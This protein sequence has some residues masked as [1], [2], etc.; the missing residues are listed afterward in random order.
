MTLLFA[1]C[2]SSSSSFFAPT[3]V[4]LSSFLSASELWFANPKIQTEFKSRCEEVNSI[5]SQWRVNADQE[6]DYSNLSSAVDRLA[7]YIDFA[8]RADASSSSSA[9]NGFL[10]AVPT[11]LLRSTSKSLVIVERKTCHDVQLFLKLCG[12][13]RRKLDLVGSRVSSSVSH[14][15]EGGVQQ[16]KSATW[17]GAHQEDIEGEFVQILSLA[18]EL[19]WTLQSVEH[20]L[21]R[22]HAEGPR[23]IE[24]TLLHFG[25]AMSRLLL[26]TT[27]NLVVHTNSNNED[28]INSSSSG[29]RAMPKMNQLQG[30]HGQQTRRQALSRVEKIALRFI[31]R[32][33]G[34]GGGQSRFLSRFLVTLCRSFLPTVNETSPWPQLI[35]AIEGTAKAAVLLLEMQEDPIA[36][37]GFISD[38]VLFNVLL[39][40]HKVPWKGLTLLSRFVVRLHCRPRQSASSAAADPN[41]RQEDI[42][43]PIETPRQLARLAFIIGFAK[44]GNK[45]LERQL[46]AALRLAKQKHAQGAAAAAGARESDADDPLQREFS[47]VKRS[48]RIIQ[49]VLTM[50]GLQHRTI[51]LADV[52]FRNIL[53]WNDHRLLGVESNQKQPNG[54]DGEAHDGGEESQLR[55]PFDPIPA[56]RIVTTKQ[57]ELRRPAL[58]SEW[59]LRV[60][61]EGRITIPTRCAGDSNPFFV[62]MIKPTQ[63]AGC[64]VRILAVDGRGLKTVADVKSALRDVVK[65]RLTC[66]IVRSN[67]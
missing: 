16:R 49:H 25:L 36:R 14:S 31:G 60:S 29:S 57:I 11:R 55:R 20:N 19:C 17:A 42:L 53:A 46:I 30:Q 47:S 50:R 9:S 38:L 18:M 4:L 62:N 61:T 44:I 54:A 28:D 24:A 37:A 58:D 34:G 59:G 51:V 48:I 65:V 10:A 56:D 21:A 5:L 6:E 15:E 13:V 22:S 40:R 12:L 52:T 41:A 3:R 26:V 45:S 32:V 64:W 67:E 43:L 63:D 66:A 2:A 1:P 35:R 23:L 8:E 27:D 39:L 33:C 7:K